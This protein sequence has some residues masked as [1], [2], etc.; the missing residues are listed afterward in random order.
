M[1]VKI[2]NAPQAPAI[3]YDRVHMTALRILQPLYYDDSLMPKYRV[4]VEYRLYGIYNGERHY[5]IGDVQQVIIDDY[6]PVAT[7]AL[8]DGDPTL[9][10]AL[11]G[12]EQ[13]VAAILSEMRG[14]NTTIV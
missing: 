4:E 5:Q 6:I 10:M 3:A 12:I 13:A 9:M 11:G 1:G 7:V 14:L 2:A 8:I